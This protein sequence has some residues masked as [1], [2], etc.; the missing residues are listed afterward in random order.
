M[1]RPDKRHIRLTD[2]SLVRVS[3]EAPVAGP[4]RTDKLFGSAG[5]GHPLVSNSSLEVDYLA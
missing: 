3:A 5:S 1:L 4:N 2:R